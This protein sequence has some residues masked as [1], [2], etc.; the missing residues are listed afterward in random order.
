V[1]SNS[2]DR[3]LKGFFGTFGAGMKL[4]ISFLQ[5]AL[6]SQQLNYISLVEEIPG[7]EHWPIR[8]LFQRNVDHGRVQESILPWLKDQ[9]SIKFFNPLTLLL[10]PS[11]NFDPGSNFSAVPTAK[12]YFTETNRGYSW[13][14]S[15][16]PGLYRFRYALINGVQHRSLG[17]VAWNSS[18][19]HIV[20]IDGQHRL[21]AL[22]ELLNDPSTNLDWNIPV[23]V[24]G[25]NPI[26]SEPVPHSPRL[27]D[28]ARS[29]F[30]Y[31][32]TQAMK[33]TESRQ[34]LLNDEHVS[35]ICT[36][37]ILQYAHDSDIHTTHNSHQFLPLQIFDWRGETQE[38]RPVMAPAAILSSVELSACLDNY[39][40][41]T[42]EH[43]GLTKALGVTPS[44]PLAVDVS[45]NQISL[46]LSNS[47]REN[48]RDSVLPG[49]V[50]LFETFP[51]FREYG[52]RIREIEAKYETDS[53]AARKAL[54]MLKFGYQSARTH[55]P[56]NVQI[57]YSDIIEDLLDA[58]AKLPFLLTH[59]VGLRSISYSFGELRD[60][61]IAWHGGK[62]EKSWKAYANWFV[63]NL[64]RCH[65][66]GIFTARMDTERLFLTRTF[67]GKVLNYRLNDVPKAFGPLLTIFIIFVSSN[68]SGFPA[69]KQ[70]NEY[71]S[72]S[73]RPKLF[74]TL[75]KGYYSHYKSVL[76]AENPHWT[77]SHIKDKA[78]N[79]AATASH[80][81]VDR[82]LQMRLTLGR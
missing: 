46:C 54:S 67:G 2:Y 78:M 28:V 82:I 6:S 56:R 20:A 65:T 27:L 22:R 57:A 1:V 76:A 79:K 45:G 35:H 53:A 43:Q 36:Q 40:L 8:D 24:T 34:I 21:T 32:N 55:W 17:E 62:K 41:K 14:V 58:K 80:K 18:R 30:V 77:Q 60:L 37:E 71:W 12:Q 7:S 10:L 81:H 38:G 19:V 52:L 16:S 29:M 50:T 68:S 3:T 66:E 64:N 70:I 63:D 31:I 61:W 4:E 59:D 13:K 47:L 69:E 73:V 44:D 9:N 51:P 25:I 49:I 5:T 42:S 33:P 39:I 75:K 23:V 74:S 26:F 48:F 15:E 11:D 72:Y